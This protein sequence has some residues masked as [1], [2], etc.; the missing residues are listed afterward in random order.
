M[1][2]LLEQ[3][4]LR[5][6]DKLKIISIKRLQSLKSEINSFQEDEELNGF[7]RWIVN[8]MYQFDVPTDEFIIKS[9][10]LIAVPHPAY[11]N[12]Q[13]VKQGKIYNFASLAMSDFDISEKYIHKLLTPEGYHIK[14]PPTLPLKRLAVQSGLAAYGRNNISYIEGMGSMFSLIA[15]FT[16]I[17][18]EN[19][20]WLEVH[21]QEQCSNCSICYDNCPTGAIR[22]DRFLIDNEKCL[23]YFNEG[24]GE[25]PEW[26]PL[27]VHHCLYDCLK[28]QIYCPMNEEYVENVAGPIKF[29]EEE[30]D[31]L[32]S[33][34]TLDEFTPELKQKAKMLGLDKWLDAIPRNLK[35]LFELNEHSE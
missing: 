25:F 22:S 21:Q 29:N 3:E 19:D 6:G 10:I 11:A 35:V 8:D 17:P 14:T 23:S 7:Q 2:K 1:I 18:C 9:I 16:D 24:G 12:A 15:Y 13:F 5:N 31:M 26:L 27:S 32:L 34:K 4:A 30:T 20:E 33:G 28:C